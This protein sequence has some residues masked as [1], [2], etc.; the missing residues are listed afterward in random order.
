MITE[1]WKIYD[2]RGNNLNLTPESYLNLLISSNTGKDA[3]GYALTDPS[4]LINRTCITNGGFGYDN[5]T[6]VYLDYLLSST[7]ISIDNSVFLKDISI[8]NP[9]L[10]NSKAISAITIDSSQ[11]FLYPSVT[12]VGA[13][14]LDPVSHGLI[15][16]E[17]LILLQDS[18]YGYVTPY[19][20]SNSTLVFKMVGEETQIQLFEVNEH[21]QEITWSDEIII[22]VST[23]IVNQGI[24][25]NIGF[26]SDEEGVYERKLI[27]YHRINTIDY[28]LIELIVNAQSI[29]EDQRYDTLLDNFGLYKPK[30]IPKLF[31]ESDINEDNLDWNLLN[32]KAKHL[33]LEHDKIMPFIGTYKGLINAIKWLGYEDIQV[34]EWFKDVKANKLLSLYVPYDSTDRKKTIKYFSPEQRKNLKK[35]NQLSLVYCITRETGE[36]DEWGNPQTENCYEYNLDEIYVKLYS[37]KSWLEKNIIGVN[38]RIY[39]ITGEGVYFERYKN[40]IYGTQNIGSNIQYE[41]SLTPLTIETDSELVNGDASLS[42]TLKEFEKLTIQDLNCNFIDF[43]RYGWDPSNG[44]FAPDQYELLSY[45]DPSAVFI[46]SPLSY[47]FIDLYDI[48]WKLLLEKEYGVVTS[49]FVSRPLFIFENEIK[50]YNIF[51]TSSYFYDISANVDITITNGY[52]RDPSIDV[53]GDALAY[54]IYPE[55]TS[56]GVFTGKYVLESSAGITYYTWGE[57]S[58][59][60]SSNPNLK[61]SYDNIY[62]VPLLTIEGYKFT[63]CSGV[64][65]D[66]EHQFIME[67]LD[68]NISMDSSK[69]NTNGDVIEVE[70]LINFTYDTSLSEQQIS[71]CV[72]YS[73]PRMP[74]FNFDPSDASTLYYNKDASLTLLDDNSIYNFNVNHKGDYELEIYGWN[75]NNNLFFNFDR[76][77]YKVWQ[78]YPTINSYI[79]TSCAGYIEYSCTSTYISKEDVSILIYENKDPLFERTFAI[80]GLTFEYDDENKPYI[81]VPSISYFIDVPEIGS[82]CKFYNLTEKIY[83]I[84]RDH[85][86]VNTDYQF[87]NIDDSVYIVGFDK[88]KYNYVSQTASC[89]TG[90]YYQE[91]WL[92]NTPSNFN[93]DPSIDWY[94]INNSFRVVSNIENNSDNTFYCDINTGDVSYYYKENQLLSFIIEDLSTNYKWGSA[95]RVLDSSTYSSYGIKHII[96]GQIPEHIINDPSK[97]SVTTKN[98]FSTFV[99]FE[100]SVKESK[101]VDNNFNLYLNDTYYHQYYLDN[102]FTFLNLL[103]EQEKVLTQW[104]DA[105]DNLINKEFYPFDHAIELDIST[106][107]ILKAEFDSSNYML[108]QKNIW[109]IKN[110]NTNKLLMIVHNSCVPYIFDASGTYDITVKSYDSYGNLVEKTFEGLL[111]INE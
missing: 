42:V 48:Q 91:F 110:R 80:E 1:L 97:Y 104:Y 12:Y 38:S 13:L 10:S 88:G 51:D 84:D 3:T 53:W 72:Y 79:D 94:L 24:Q 58:L 65:R 8:Y 17:H 37:L 32:Y 11:S 99:D 93:L 4:G 107:V 57:F 50:F 81:K 96:E 87:F 62:Q 52:L 20:S 86:F 29:G 105:S 92:Y 111:K 71:L 109:E 90:G 14:F 67:I 43:A 45:V 59:Q 76:D 64:V 25:I 19:D 39:D 74:I 9:A 44:F 66:L 70:N 108:N 60:T 21:T 78:K 47:P 2:K 27:L 46:G 77:G 35:L 6:N 100:M 85:I 82:I 101:E 63:D 40:L 41:Q 54:T 103:F 16:T 23:Y 83:Y 36:I 102:T 31:K 95:Y 61:Y 69:L 18:S 89:I 68:G 34:K 30:S 75:G 28:P 7:L 33:I 26:V 49:D 22:D 15:E 56:M 106:L 73:S 55:E 5:S 98:A